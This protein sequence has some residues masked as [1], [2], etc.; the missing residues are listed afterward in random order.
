MIDNVLKSSKNYNNVKN[1]SFNAVKLPDV[2]NGG[3]Y[4]KIDFVNY[5]TLVQGQNNHDFQ[6]LY[7]TN[8]RYSKYQRN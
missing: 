5:Y 1:Y 6:N 2:Y 7:Q 8:K 3:C 4:M